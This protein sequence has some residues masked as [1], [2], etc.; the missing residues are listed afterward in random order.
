MAKRPMPTTSKSRTRAPKSVPAKTARAAPD[1]AT[2]ADAAQTVRISNEMA[3]KLAG[4]SPRWLTEQRSHGCPVPDGGVRTVD[5]VAAIVKWRMDQQRADLIADRDMD[6]DDLDREEQRTKLKALQIKLARELDLVLDGDDYLHHLS[7]LWVEMN[8]LLD[9]MGMQLGPI[10]ATISDPDVCTDKIDEFV[11][12]LKKRFN[13]EEAM[14]PVRIELDPFTD[15][16]VGIDL[17]D[18]VADDD[19]S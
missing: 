18:D 19:E 14:N 3:A 9:V 10:V 2:R 13:P 17:D 11:A 16:E 5:Q 1:D 6:E 7:V 15:D 4:I 8:S 12:D